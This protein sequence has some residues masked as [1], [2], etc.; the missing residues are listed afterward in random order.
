MTTIIEIKNKIDLEKYVSQDDLCQFMHI[1][2][3][4]FTDAV[5]SISKAI[6]YAFSSEGGKGGFLLLAYEGEELA[7][8]LVMNATGMS[9]FIPE[10]YLVYI[11]VH[12]KHRG[13]GI[14]TQLIQKSFEICDGEVALHV[15]YDNP[16]AR[17]YKRMGFTSKYA[18]MRWKKEV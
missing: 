4:K 11:V 7:G 6:D 2:L 18:E 3:D 13:K 16:A 15:E 9:G 10:Y 8:S 17:L 12:E 14:G 1:H 5:S